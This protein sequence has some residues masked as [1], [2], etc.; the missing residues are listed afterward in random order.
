MQHCGRQYRD[1]CGVC[2]NVSNIVNQESIF[3]SN[4]GGER[5]HILCV[6]CLFDNILL[7]YIV[8]FMNQ[9][10][11]RNSICRRAAGGLKP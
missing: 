9:S 7:E 6:I 11:A 4:W 2:L 1:H 5:V 10:V 8:S 3:G